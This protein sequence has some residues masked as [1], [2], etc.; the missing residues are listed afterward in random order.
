M[1][2]TVFR[3]TRIKRRTRRRTRTI[4]RNIEERVARTELGSLKFTYRHLILASKIY[5]DRGIAN[6]VYKVSTVLYPDS[7]SWIRM[8]LKCMALKV[9]VNGGIT[10]GLV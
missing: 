4:R 8:A 9:V 2:T 1:V 7:E 5:S 10:K 3:T 6:G